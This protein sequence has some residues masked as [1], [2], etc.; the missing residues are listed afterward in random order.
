MQIEADIVITNHANIYKN[1]RSVAFDALMP[2][3][4]CQEGHLACLNLA[5][6][7]V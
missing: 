4:G 7:V 5:L 2:L 6:A 1:L 3:L